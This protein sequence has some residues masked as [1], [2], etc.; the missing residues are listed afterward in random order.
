MSKEVSQENRSLKDRFY[1]F[2]YDFEHVY[3]DKR[4]SVD[5]KK[6]TKKLDYNLLC[7]KLNYF[8]QLREQAS[9]ENIEMTVFNE[10]IKG[11]LKKMG[12]TN[13]HQFPI[14]NNI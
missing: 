3:P 7:E 13:S 2:F 1:D 6:K 5:K 12:L 11:L 14:L 9:A 10:A 8:Y 4:F